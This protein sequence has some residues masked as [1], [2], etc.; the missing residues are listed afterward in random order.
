MENKPS[1][2]LRRDRLGRFEAGHPWIFAGEIEKME[3]ET[4]PGGL[5]AVRD[6][7]GR[8]LGTGYWNPHSQI[9]VRVV[10]YGDL[11]RMDE[12]WFRRRFA[13]CLEHR[14]R[15]S[16]GAASGRLVNAEAD[17]LPGLIVDR[18]ADVLVVQVLTLGMEMARDA[19]LP[20]LVETFRP[21]GV[22]ERSDV[23][24]RALEGLPERAGLL[25]GVCPERVLIEENGLKMEVDIAAGQKT[26]H[27]FDQRENR[28]AIAPLMTGWG[29]RSGIVLQERD[30]SRVPVNR[31]GKEVTFPRWDGATVLDAFAHTG[32]FT[33]HA[34]KF[35]AKSVT[36]LDVSRQAIEL[37]RRNVELNGFEDRVEFV[38]DNAFEYLRRHVRG[39]EERL[40][41]ADAGK[42]GVKI[43]TSK[44][45]PAEGRTWDVIILDPPAF[46]KTKR[47]VP[48]AIR[49]Y[50]DVNLHALKLINEGGYLVTAS[51]S[52]HVRPE[53]FLDI[54]REAARDAGKVLRRIEWRGAAKDH[55]LLL[56]AEE[57]DYLK[58]GIFE[59]QSKR[60]L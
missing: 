1:V 31:K 16:G 4:E 26:G 6:H 8:L 23:G 52:Y 14:A 7:R 40:R 34:C 47:A 50:K 58:F 35:G 27:F 42:P 55:P 21:R 56:A 13:W 30:G 29:A 45:L 60:E 59:V 46:A 28:A 3:G 9:A 57:G 10:S 49:G 43:D 22:Y 33:L 17:F 51:C 24:V 36:C 15:F 39:R 12:A 2:V 53:L 32:G 37:A 25:W 18:F 54:I 41:R 11:E 48:D 19:W 38:V 20:A 5:V 44:P